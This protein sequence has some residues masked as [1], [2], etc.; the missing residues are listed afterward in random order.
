MSKLKRIISHS[1]FW[2][3]SATFLAIF[4]GRNTNNIGFTL[5][6]VSILLPV[7][8]ITSY[9]FN[10]Y[11]IPNFLF[12]RRYFKFGLYS[13]FVVTFSIYLQVLVM[14]FA[15][16]YIVDYNYDAM[17]PV[18]TNIINL[19]VS[20]YVIV[21]L[22][23]LIYLIKR[24]SKPIQEE[25]I[26][27]NI[28]LIVKVNRENVRLDTDTIEYIESLDNYVK[29]HTNERSYITKEKIS[30]L[31]EKLPDPFLRIHR[32]FIVN[33][34]KIEAFTKENVTLQSLKLPISRTYKKAAME[35]L[36]PRDNT[37]IKN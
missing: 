24:W 5:T 36:Q 26:P 25:N 30:S 27:Q 4:L 37:M 6:L 1:I 32:S 18:S 19:G 7:A 29:I 16:I 31:A 2:A 12:N 17:N 28:P 8:C 35:I 11:L 15:L 21:F 9:T 13:F 33:Q 14:V 3:L 23:A 10:Y 34:R 22:S 20:M